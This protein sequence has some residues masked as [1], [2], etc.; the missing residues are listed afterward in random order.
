MTNAQLH[1]RTCT[2]KL[3]HCVPTQVFVLE[4][5]H[6]VLFPSMK[7]LFNWSSK[8]LSCEIMIIRIAKIRQEVFFKTLLVPNKSLIIHSN[9]Q[10]APQR[11]E[12]RKAENKNICRRDEHRCCHYQEN[13]YEENYE[14]FS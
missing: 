13:N 4:S 3:V 11:D 1:A 14:E 7:P 8:D 2:M 12:E 9:L 6:S 10:F 5:Y